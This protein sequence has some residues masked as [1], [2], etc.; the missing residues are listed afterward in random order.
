MPITDKQRNGFGV[1]LNEAD[2]L[3]FEVVPERRAAA[4]TFRVLTLPED[5]PPP[6]DRRVQIVFHPVGRVAASLRNGADYASAEVVPFAIEEL[7]ATVESFGGLPVYGWEFIDL[8]ERNFR[9]WSDRLSLDWT[10]GED[11][12]SHSITVFQESGDRT[13]EIRV[14]FDELKIYDPEFNEISID[15][16]IDGGERWWDGFYEGD[17]QTD[18]YG[19]NLLEDTNNKEA[20]FYKAGA[21]SIALIFVGATY[22]VMFVTGYQDYPVD[23]HWILDL[24]FG[25]SAAALIL[26][27]LK[28]L[29]DR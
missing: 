17:E 28:W 3:G 11:G 8:P 10:S 13:L 26:R 15:A 21:Y 29:L 2:L 1:A 4:A 24:M 20:T 14:W 27:I 19:L 6:D 22:Y 18:G 23:L 9:T 12:R 25:V 16:F 7:L 5:G